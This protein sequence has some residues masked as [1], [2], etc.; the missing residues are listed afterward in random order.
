MGENEVHALKGIDLQIARGEMTAIVGMS[1]SGKSTLMNI[2]G[3]LDRCT[4]GRYFF[5]DEDVSNLI[6]HELAEIRNHENWIYLSVIFFAAA[7]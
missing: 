4:T 7:V 1:G 5:G 6:E 2:I 3:F